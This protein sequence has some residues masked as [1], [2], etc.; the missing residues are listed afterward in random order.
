MAE[1]ELGGA[2]ALRVYSSAVD[3][4]LDFSELVE[5]DFVV[6]I[7]GARVNSK[8]H[9]FRSLTDLGGRRSSK[10]SG[11]AARLD[12]ADL[13]DGTI[14]IAPIASMYQVLSI[15]PSQG[16]KSV[17][18]LIALAK[19]KPGHVTYGS[20]GIGSGAHFAAEKLRIALNIDALHVP[21]KSTGDMVVPLKNGELQVFNETPP[22][23]VQHI[24]RSFDP[25][26]V[27]TVH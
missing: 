22:V 4:L 7:I 16:I 3:Q 24:V 11:G 19:A 14:E 5:G 8:W 18:Q 27:C 21:Y 25:C 20:A 12:H 26:M 10:E 9:L 23:A 17:A 1:R 6:F 13:S 15:A 2:V